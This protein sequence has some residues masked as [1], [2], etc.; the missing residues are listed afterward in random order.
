M[1][2]GLKGGK[3]GEG[4]GIYPCRP[5]QIQMQQAQI[6]IKP[7]RVHFTTAK[8]ILFIFILNAVETNL[9]ALSPAYCKINKM[10]FFFR[11][12]ISVLAQKFWVQHWGLLEK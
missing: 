11:N 1:K 12:V 6:R 5:F 10:N 2:R 4:G 9:R 8:R 7:E 3:G